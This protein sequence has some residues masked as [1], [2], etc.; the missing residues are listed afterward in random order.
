MVRNTLYFFKE[1]LRGFYQ[2]KLMTFVSVVTIGLALF[3]WGPS[4]GLFEHKDLAETGLQPRGSGRL[5]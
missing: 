3:S 2:A 4:R 1:A 5:H